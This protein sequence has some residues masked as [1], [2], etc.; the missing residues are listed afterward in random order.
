MRFLIF[1]FA[2]LCCPVYAVT[3]DF[4]D[5]EVKLMLK[6]QSPNLVGLTHQ[7]VKLQLYEDQFLLSQ[8]KALRSDWLIRQSAVGFTTDY[9][10][11]R[12]LITLLKAMTVKVAVPNIALDLYTSA[13]LMTRLQNYAVNGQVSVE[14]RKKWQEIVLFKDGS[15]QVT[16]DDLYQQLS[17]QM[18]FKLH[19]G[20]SDIFKRELL[21]YVSQ[22]MTI[23]NA[24][25]SLLASEINML[26]LKDIA[27]AKVLRPA[28]RGY[29]GL[30]KVMHVDSQYLEQVKHSVTKKEIAEFYLQHKEQFTFIAK[31]DAWGA[32]FTDQQQAQDFRNKVIASSWHSTVKQ[33][34]IVDIFSPFKHQLERE[35]LHRY[36]PAQSAFALAKNSLSPVMRTPKGEWLVIKTGDQYT[37]YYAQDSENVNYLA[38]QV[39]ADKKAYQRFIKAKQFWL[40]S[41]D[42][43]L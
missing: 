16:L 27:L 21:N 22:L 28:I 8:V 34:A 20:D 31:V 32:I 36:W 5:N 39:L 33:M 42:I 41:N 11:R 24:T 17:M 37:D 2:I 35:L 43:A 38:R 7:Q 25:K 40:T 18:R 12:Y 13:W 3:T 6:V 26:H 1:W 15:I 10:V 9:H 29:L 19:Q 30:A 23:K 14:R 4:S